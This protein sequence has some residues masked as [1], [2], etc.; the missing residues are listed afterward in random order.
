MSGQYPRQ[1]GS[2]PNFPYGDPR[3]NATWPYPPGTN[4]AQ[5]YPTAQSY[6]AAGPVYPQYGQH[7][8]AP[9]GHGYPAPN[10]GYGYPQG[11]TG[12]TPAYGHSYPGLAQT[13]G[14]Q[15]PMN[16]A[17]GPG[18]YYGPGQGQYPAPG[19]SPWPGQAHGHSPSQ[20]DH[21]DQLSAASDSSP[22]STES[23]Q[24]SG[25]PALDAKR[26]RNTISARR[27]RVRKMEELETLQN[28]VNSI[29]NH[30]SRMEADKTQMEEELKTTNAAVAHQRARISEQMRELQEEEG[31][32]GQHGQ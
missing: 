14:Y 19:Q 18:G 27:G 20:S 15:A 32:S 13:Q 30:V 9:P 28:Q 22:G 26:L 2:N 23:S 11:T 5:P 25:D 31:T 7:Q 10:P 4:P 29:R 6:Q 8:G 24:G 16:P 12:A 1:R 17:V 3:S 21:G